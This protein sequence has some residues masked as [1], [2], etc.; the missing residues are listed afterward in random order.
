M[1][2]LLKFRGITVAEATIAILIVAILVAA[3]V[4]TYLH[5]VETQRLKGAAEGARVLLNLAR[6]EA[7]KRNISIVMQ[8]IP[9][10]N[11]CYGVTTVY[12]CDCNSPANC[13]LGQE[14]ATIYP[15]T[16]LSTTFS[17]VTGQSF[18]VVFQ[19]D[20]GDATFSGTITFTGSSGR[21]IVVTV[22]KQGLVH[23]CSDT[24]GGY[25]SC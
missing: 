13:D 23:I 7:L 22:I 18:E 15:G 14:S 17:G 9:G 25:G 11:W 6:S 8:I 20:R 12:F 5:Y 2:N 16:T 10:S 1:R 4:P 19:P 24:V 3:A 21:S